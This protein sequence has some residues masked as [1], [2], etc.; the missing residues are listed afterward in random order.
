MTTFGGN[1]EEVIERTLLQAGVSFD[2]VDKELASLHMGIQ[3]LSVGG[4]VN[5]ITRNGGATGWETGISIRWHILLTTYGALGSLRNI[6]FTRHCIPVQLRA[7]LL[8]DRLSIVANIVLSA[9]TRAAD[10]YNPVAGL[11]LLHQRGAI[12][13]GI[14]D[15]VIRI[16]ITI[17]AIEWRSLYGIRFIS[18][19]YICRRIAESALRIEEHRWWAGS[20]DCIPV[21][22]AQVKHVAVLRMLHKLTNQMIGTYSTTT[23]PDGHRVCGLRWSPG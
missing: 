22:N 23:L 3:M 13:G 12:S 17:S 10:I 6:A 19:L 15:H 18:A 5:E 4:A 14:R 1:I 21:L 7:A 9:T 11:L 8:Q 16:S 20:Q 2:A